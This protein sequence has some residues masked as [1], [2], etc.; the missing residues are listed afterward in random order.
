MSQPCRHWA[1]ALRDPCFTVRCS[2]ARAL[3]ELGEGARQAVPDLIEALA[4]PEPGVRDAVAASLGAL[5][6]TA[7]LAVPFL[8]EALHDPNRFVRQA[9]ARALEQIDPAAAAKAR[10]RAAGGEAPPTP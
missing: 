8:A 6:R 3:G 10:A 7:K 5:G 2:A 1:E 9:A 4:D